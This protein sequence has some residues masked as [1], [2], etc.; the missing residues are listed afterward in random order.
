MDFNLGNSQEIREHN[1]NMFEI[2]HFISEGLYAGVLNLNGNVMSPQEV[3]DIALPRDTL[4][5]ISYG[6]VRNRVYLDMKVNSKGGIVG[7]D[8]STGK[9]IR[10]VI[11]GASSVNDLL[12]RLLELSIRLRTGSTVNLND[13][14]ARM[15]LNHGSFLHTD[16][17]HHYKNY[18]D[19]FDLYNTYFVAKDAMTQEFR[20]TL[21]HPLKRKVFDGVR[22]IFDNLY[23][24]YVCVAL[25]SLVYETSSVNEQLGLPKGGNHHDDSTLITSTIMN[26]AVRGIIT[27]MGQCSAGVTTSTG[28][29]SDEL[30][31]ARSK[32]QTDHA[33]KISIENKL[34]NVNTRKRSSMIMK[35]IY[36]SL[37][38]LYF[39][40]M[41]AL[42]VINIGVD[43]DSKIRFSMVVNSLLLTAILSYDIYRLAKKI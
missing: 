13:I 41:I 15:P 3:A 5:A 30:D 37:F 43:M 33:R 25:L 18:P 14:E 32:Y 21:T 39:F 23:T 38:L 6:Y 34:T 1:R 11:V 40:T 16:L 31:D 28:Q 2:S 22:D 29:V 36:L 24:A 19:V 12:K 27:D 26:S 20:N 42:Y 35:F 9:Q 17:E 4:N 7:S 8:E 10:D